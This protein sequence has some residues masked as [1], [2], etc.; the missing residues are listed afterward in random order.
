MWATGG[1]ASQSGWE[2][3]TPAGW[4][5]AGVVATQEHHPQPGLVARFVAP[6]M[7]RLSL[8]RTGRVLPA[9][10]ELAPCVAHIVRMLVGDNLLPRGCQSVHR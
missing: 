5:A 8:E 3:R 7:A 9:V 4:G 10:V 6:S 1:E 2:G